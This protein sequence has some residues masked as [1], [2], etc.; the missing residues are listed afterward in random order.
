VPN[1]AQLALGDSGD[2]PQT[3]RVPKAQ[4]I[5]LLCAN[6]SFDGSGAAGDYLPAI[7]LVSDA[8]EVV[9]R[10]FGDQ[11]TAGDSAEVTFGAFLGGST[12]IRFGVFNVG[13]FLDV[14][15]SG[16]INF[17]GDSFAYSVGPAPFVFL[18]GN[19]TGIDIVASDQTFTTNPEINVD[20]AGNVFISA[21]VAAGN[22]PIT[23]KVDGANGPVPPGGSV[24]VFTG[25]TELFRVDNDG[26][27]HGLTGQALTFDL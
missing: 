22:N 9:S 23:I 14:T 11:V 8:D 4:L 13:S 26:A 10:T 3:Y 17:V 18:R 16:Y 25:S 2:A 1:Q 20:A 24:R 15:G 12:G 27:L 6:A 19:G 21:G 7:E 5:R